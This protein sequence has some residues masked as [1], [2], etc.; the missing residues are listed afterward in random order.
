[1][2]SFIGKAQAQDVHQESNFLV[3]VHVTSANIPL[4]KGTLM[5]KPKVK[6]WESILFLCEAVAEVWVC[7]I[8]M[9]D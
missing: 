6:G 2:Y 3:S 9:A 1:M 4:A 8:I 5:A 7:S